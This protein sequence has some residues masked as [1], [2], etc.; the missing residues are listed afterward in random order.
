[1]VLYPVFLLSSHHL[2][3]H[4]VLWGLAHIISTAIPPGQSTQ[5]FLP[6]RRCF[7][8]WKQLL[9]LADISVF[10]ESGHSDCFPHLFSNF[11]Q[12]GQ[13]KYFSPVDCEL[14]AVCLSTRLSLSSDSSLQRIPLGPSWKLTHEIEGNWPY[15]EWLGERSL[16]QP[17]GLRYGHD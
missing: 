14:T 7:T 15:R 3:I 16:C 2:F 17:I 5:R 6:S 11:T 8:I 12:M 10:P 9:G 1:M 4:K 13:C